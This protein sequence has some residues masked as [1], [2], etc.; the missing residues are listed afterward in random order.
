MPLHRPA[1]GAIACLLAAAG[2]GGCA[3][4]QVANHVIQYNATSAE[5]HNKR[6]LLAHSC[7]AVS[8][9]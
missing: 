4:Q 5:V 1:R 9:P 8:S 2:L 7:R 3:N 6:P